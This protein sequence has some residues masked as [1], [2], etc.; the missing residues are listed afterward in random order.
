MIKK[1]RLSISEE[2]GGFIEI[3]AESKEEAW[4]TAGELMD[5]YGVDKLFYADWN[6]AGCDEDLTKYNG[7]HTHR[8]AQVH[9]C[10]EI[11]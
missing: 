6:T 3:K 11:K 10:E 8:D 9:T 4:L 5:E 1:Y 2:I 7:K